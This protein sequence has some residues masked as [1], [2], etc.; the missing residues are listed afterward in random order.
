MSANLKRKRP[1]EVTGTKVLVWLLLF[2]GIVFAV[3]GVM[4][5]AAISTFGG[6]ETKSSYQAGL[7]FEQDVATAQ[8]QDALH[9]Q[10]SGELARDGTGLA[11]LDV[12]ARDA[13]GTPLNGLTADARLAHP[14]DERLDHAIPLQPKAAGIFRGSAEAQPGQWDLIIDLYR[15]DTRVFRSQS[16]VTLK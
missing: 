11:N 3:N 6:V 5:R 13:K 4:V 1:G 16:R 7:K 15:G 10:V 2:F 8:R 9:W 14:A 12:T